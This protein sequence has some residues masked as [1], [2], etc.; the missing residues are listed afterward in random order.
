[1][2]I[3]NSYN[4]EILREK[5]RSFN[6]YLIDFVHRIHEN[7]EQFFVDFESV[8]FYL[9]LILLRYCFTIKFATKFYKERHF[10]NTMYVEN[11]KFIYQDTM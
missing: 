3:E 6:C 1:M 10:S 5:L 4:P 2:Y 7:T 11:D 9:I 8:F